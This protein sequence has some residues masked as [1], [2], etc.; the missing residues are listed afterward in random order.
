LAAR[1]QI[2]L[3]CAEGATIAEVAADLGV[4][5]NMV[6]KRRARFVT[7]RLDGLAD[8]PRPENCR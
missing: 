4:S 2:V 8:E 6:S 5:R 7:G 3:R 1:S